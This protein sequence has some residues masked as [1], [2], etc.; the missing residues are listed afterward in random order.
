M[1]WWALTDLSLKIQDSGS[2]DMCFWQDLKERSRCW[3]NLHIASLSTQLA[4]VAGIASA[5]S[6]G[7]I[8]PVG[9]NGI[10]MEKK[11]EWEIKANV[12]S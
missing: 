9:T 7:S 3:H 10:N 11:E 1:N 12:R 8:T 4:P 6:R 2:V 5:S